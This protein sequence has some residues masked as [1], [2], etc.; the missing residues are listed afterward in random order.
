MSN[1]SN[2]RLTELADWSWPDIYG[3]K[4]DPVRM[5][6]IIEWYP[7]IKDKVVRT[8]LNTVATV[9]SAQAEIA[10]S[11]SGAAKE[12]LKQIDAIK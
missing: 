4:T 9:F 11:Y 12:I 10:N 1:G 3:P 8:R 2:E 6:R 7:A 5:F